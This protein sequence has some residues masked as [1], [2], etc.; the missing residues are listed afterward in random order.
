MF[1]KTER[2]DEPRTTDRANVNAK[3]LSITLILAVVLPFL[4]LWAVWSRQFR[5]ISD[6][7]AMD[8]AQVARNVGA[9]KGFTT[10]IIRPLATTNIQNMNR[11]PD[12]VHAPLFAIA[13]GVAMAGGSASDLKAFLVSCAFFLLTIPVLF[14]V[15]KAMF[16]ERVAQLTIFA[17]ITS[18]FMTNM[19]LTCGPATMNGFV[20]TLLCLAVLRYAQAASPEAGVPDTRAVMIRGGVCGLLFALCYL[21]DY[22]L[23]FAFLPVAAC[24]YVVGKREGKVGLTAFLLV[25]AIVGGGWMLRNTH[26]TGNPFF[27]L[28]AMEIGM[29]TKTHPGMSL[30]RTTVPQSVLGLL[31]E[32]ISEQPRKILQGIQVAY[33]ALP[34][35]GQP[36]LVAFFIV[37]LFY[38][39]RRSGVNALRGMLIGSMICVAVFGGLFLFQ[40]NTLTAFAPI[41][42]AFAAAFFV[43][44][45]T[46][47]KA[48][49][50]V[51]KAVSTLAVVLLVL[52]L[53]I[54]L[55]VSPQTRAASHLIET[56]V[57]RRVLPSV[58]ILTDRAFETTW[59]GSRTTIWL[60]ETDK[61]VENLDKIGHVKAIYLSP[62][63]SPAARTAEDYGSWRELYRTIYGQAV[64]GQLATWDSG[65]FKDFLLYRDMSQDDSMAYLRSGAL[66]LLRPDAARQQ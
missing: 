66:L 25:F 33:T 13:E 37:G 18:A 16:N 17:Y 65:P 64:G 34:V 58:P 35:L 19:I 4:I 9:G 57:A 46:D 1:R 53:L 7:D 54:A 39:F 27:G 22:M 52:P 50:I 15:T 45:L 20:F 24:V 5:Q 2:A 3:R 48:P 32:T 55:I 11:M 10:S 60:P 23:L 41:M 59:Y 38:S 51:S 56:D 49:D 21:T 42:L 31:R 30:Y 40:L 29:G 8:Y 44:L 14:V 63:L 12:T 36:Y 6:A 28:K 26:L 61:D 43:R 47:S 62:N